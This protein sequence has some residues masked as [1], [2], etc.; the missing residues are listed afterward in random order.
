MSAMDFSTF[1]SRLHLIGVLTLETALRIGAGKA[2]EAAG[3]DLPVVKDAL[4]R[5]YIPGSSFKGVMRS[6]LESLLRSLRYDLACDP[7]RKEDDPGS[8][9]GFCLTMKDARGPDGRVIAKGV[10]TLKAELQKDPQGLN[11]LL[12]QRSC[13]V[14]RVFGAPWL[15]SKV[16]VKDLSVVE[17][18][19]DQWFL[20]RDGVGIDRDSETAAARLKYD[21]EAVPAG[22]RFRFELMVENASAVEKG[23]VLM[24][25][26]EFEDGRL[27]LGGARS[28]GLGW[29]KLELDWARSGHVDGPTLPEYLK[30]GQM[31]IVTPEI[32]Q[33][34]LNAF[35]QEV[36]PNA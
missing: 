5:P 6:R 7:F 15:A 33:G 26:R 14:C 29:V 1:H 36:R 2:T 28:R 30:T 23:L 34:W 18:W 3:P 21:F 4:R 16:L 13:Q 35:W 22:T 9:K 25:L 10:Q 8:V 27:P 31:P 24:G 12:W 17:P 20:L 19:F 11:D 32:R